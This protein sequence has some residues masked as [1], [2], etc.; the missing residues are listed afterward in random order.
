MPQRPYVT[1]GS[2]QEQLIYPLEA[3]PERLIPEGQLRELLARVDLEYL[4]ERWVWGRVL[5]VCW[6]GCRGTGGGGP[7]LPGDSPAPSLR[8]PP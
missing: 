2:L 4:V 7:C 8:L 3:T 6:G 5:A 1:Q